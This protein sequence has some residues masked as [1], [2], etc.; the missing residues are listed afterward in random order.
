MRK[1]LA[2]IAMVVASGALAQAQ[3]VEGRTWIGPTIGLGAIGGGLGFGVQGEYGITENIGLGADIAYTSFTE[4]FGG[5]GGM[6]SGLPKIHYSLLGVLVAGSYHFTPGKAFDPYVKVGVGYFNWDVAYEDANGNKV[7]PFAGFSASYNSGVG[8]S[9]AI[10]ARYHFSDAVSGRLSLGY[11]MLVGAGVDFAFGG[12]TPSGMAASS[13]SSSTSNETMTKTTSPEQYALYVGPYVAAKGSIITS[14]ADGAKTGPVFNVPPDLG[15]SILAPFGAGSSVGFGLDLGYATYGFELK[16]EKEATDTNTI[17]PT[18]SYINVFP[19]V[20]LGGFILGVNFGFPSSADSRTKTD[21]LVSIVGRPNVVTTT[22]SQGVKIT[23]T[24][25]SPDPVSQNGAIPYDITKYLATLVEVR[26]GGAIPVINTSA[27]KLNVNI[28]AGY[29]LSGLF[30]DH[31]S[32]LG[33]YEK[34]PST[35]LTGPKEEYN[36]K[37]VSLS[38]GFSYLFRLGF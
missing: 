29:S 21:S 5:F 26:I 24:Y 1:L 6:S 12:V 2:G 34:S 32:Y 17:T 22:N 30:T 8:L 27:G 28:M 20:N 38:I 19:H 11:P 9:G 36:P 3:F 16:P 37:P 10:G 4:D 25:F 31:Q 23:N 7:D 13:S 18:F 15:V 35:G 33:S 14:V